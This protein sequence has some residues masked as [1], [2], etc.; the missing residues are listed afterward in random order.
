M[1]ITAS[2]LKSGEG[3]PGEVRTLDKE[4]VASRERKA[5]CIPI[6]LF[7]NIKSIKNGRCVQIYVCGSKGNDRFDLQEL[8]ILNV[9]FG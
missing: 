6:L 9:D 7:L 2:N 4:T 5:R 8:K 3:K 1:I